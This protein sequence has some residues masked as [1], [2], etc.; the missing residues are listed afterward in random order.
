ML[1]SFAQLACVQPDSATK[2]ITNCQNVIRRVA[3][4]IIQEKKT[5]VADG[6]KAGAAYQGKD[7]L[8]LMRELS[9]MKVKAYKLTFTIVKSNVA[10]DLPP[11]Q[12]LT[13]DDILHSINTFM[14]AGSDTTS[15]ALA[16]TLL[17][18]AQNP[19]IQS[20][21]RSELLSI[22]PPSSTG[23]SLHNLENL[24]EDEILS[25][26]EA[27]AANPYLDNVCRESLRLVPPVHSSLRVATQDNMVPTSYPIMERTK[28]GKLRETGRTHVFVPK[29][30]FV[31]VPVEAFNLDRH[32]WGE[33]A[34][35]F[36]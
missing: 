15:L 22:L 29:G 9:A 28:D 5:K 13:D 23:T 18:L 34:W 36:M 14:F 30:T 20:R 16:W 31:H 7:L 33:D 35:K 32:I 4:K 6:D 27:I 19:T 26:Y 24:P 10:V 8:S 3:G 17:L 12:R 25:L 2:L 21:L 11:E 1:A